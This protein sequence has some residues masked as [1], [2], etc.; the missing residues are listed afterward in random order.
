MVFNRNIDKMW[1]VIRKKWVFQFF[2]HSY[3]CSISLNFE[4]HFIKG[5]RPLEILS[6]YQCLCGTF[7]SF[8]KYNSNSRQ[9]TLSF[10]STLYG[11]NLSCETFSHKR[12][13]FSFWP[14][15]FLYDFTFLIWLN[16]SFFF[17]CT[18]LNLPD[19]SKIL[20]KIPS[21]CRQ[22]WE[23]KLRETTTDFR[24]TRDHCIYLQYFLVLRS[25]W[26]S[27]RLVEYFLFKLFIFIFPRD[28]L[29]SLDQ[30]I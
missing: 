4:N 6:Y 18:N 26:L 9:K 12:C 20:T 15:H 27:P 14:L 3:W 2:F 24:L 11:E 22:H 17:M 30:S 19:L 29:H 16:F 23:V 10:F 13:N 28:A 25:I 1:K 8:I 5:S 21:Q 7:E